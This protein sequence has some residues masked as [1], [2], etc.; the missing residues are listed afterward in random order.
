MQ[1]FERNKKSG[2]QR[3]IFLRAIPNQGSVHC[4][5]SRTHLRRTEQAELEKP[6]CE[7][8][9]GCLLSSV[10]WHSPKVTSRTL[11]SSCTAV[12]PSR[13]KACTAAA[14]RLLWLDEATIIWAIISMQEASISTARALFS[15]IICPCM[16]V[17]R[18][19]MKVCRKYNSIPLG[20]QK[21]GKLDI[22]QL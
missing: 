13:I 9:R 15:C 21:H 1:K 6:E 2:H 19:L 14:M 8:A 22:D 17:D 5:G 20:V 3:N 12:A 16:Q 4:R 7:P 18:Q 10:P 11:R